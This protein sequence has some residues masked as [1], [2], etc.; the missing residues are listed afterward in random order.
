MVNFA[1]WIGVK[2]CKVKAVHVV[3][4]FKSNEQNQIKMAPTHSY[5]INEVL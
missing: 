2:V 5:R 3:L 1:L 4:W